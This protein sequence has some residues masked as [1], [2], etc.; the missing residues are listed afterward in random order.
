[1]GEPLTP[2]QTVGPFHHIEL[3]Y[4]HGGG[5]ASRSPWRGPRHGAAAGRRRAAPVDDGLIEVWQADPSGA[6]H[7]PAD[8]RDLPRLEGFTGFGRVATAAD[9]GFELWTVK[10]GPVPGPH[11]SAQAPHLLVTVLARG[12]LDRLVTRMYF[13][14]EA[15]ANAA[16]P[17]L[18]LVGD[19]VARATLVAHPDG[20][21][22]ALRHPPSRRARDGVLCHLRGGPRRR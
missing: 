16:D 12:L 7:H 15:D 1:M 11:G 19:P 2:S 10:P 14:D 5:R 13:P 17:I 20:D 3:P 18:S 6:F 8:E 9:G 4:P 21:A 22:A